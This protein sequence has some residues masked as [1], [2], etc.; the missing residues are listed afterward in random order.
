MNPKKICIIGG[1]GFVGSALVNRLS[2][3]KHQVK[4]F[5]RRPERNRHLKLLPGV[6]LS[7]IDYFAPKVLERHFD[8]MDVVINLVGILNPKNKDSFNKV[9][10]E[11]SRRIVEAASAVKVKRLLHMSALNAGNQAS[12]YL[13]TKG[14][15][16]QIAHQC[17]NVDVTIFCPSIIYGANDHFFNMFANFLNLPGPFPVIGAKARFSPIYVEDVVDAFI[18]SIDQPKTFGKSYA[19]CGPKE[20]SLFDLVSY[21]AK[22]TNPKASIIPLNWFFSKIMAS[23]MNIIPGAPISLDNYHSMTVDSTCAQNIAAELCVEPVSLETVLPLY[24]GDKEVNS[25]YNHL[26]TKASR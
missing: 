14:Q 22:I 26:R 8:G 2:K 25:Y 9:H 1:T 6:S 7:T 20:Y 15:G 5:S 16:Q 11:L 18:N 23:F 24:L 4:I 17:Q 12:K 10:V 19:L 13:V 3:L 21:T